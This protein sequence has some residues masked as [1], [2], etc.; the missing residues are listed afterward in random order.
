MSI[1]KELSQIRKE[2]NSPFI[3]RRFKLFTWLLTVIVPLVLYSI[4]IGLLFSTVI[5][6]LNIYGPFNTDFNTIE[7]AKTSIGSLLNNFSRLIDSLPQFAIL[8]FCAFPIFVSIRI[9]AFLLNIIRGWSDYKR[10]VVP[11]KKVFITRLIMQGFI[12]LFAILVLVGY[13]LIIQYIIT[14]S[15]GL[16]NEASTLIKKTN[17]IVMNATN[18]TEIENAMNSFND[19]LNNIASRIEDIVS[20]ETQGYLMSNFI[21]FII[22][23]GLW[24]LFGLAYG[25]TIKVM[26]SNARSEFGISKPKTEKENKKLRNKKEKYNDANNKENNEADNNLQ[27]DD[28]INSDIEQE[29]ANE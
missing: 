7:E 13:I 8:I 25:I 11:V 12:I 26:L 17:D 4:G 10:D 21:L 2:K 14:W 15:S 1:R 6:S 20:D 27:P 24:L 16:V 9:V 19:D 29:K 23:N 3:I 22:G 5:D 28:G 18:Q